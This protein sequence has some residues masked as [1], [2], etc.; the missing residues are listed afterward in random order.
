MG[1]SQVARAYF[2]KF[3]YHIKILN[4]VSPP[5]LKVVHGKTNQIRQT[6][7]ITINT[8]LTWQGINTA[9]SEP[10]V[11]LGIIRYLKYWKPVVQPTIMMFW[12]LSMGISNK[13][14]SYV[15]ITSGWDKRI[16]YL[17][18]SSATGYDRSEPNHHKTQHDDVIKWK[19]FPRNWPF[20]RGIHRSPVN[21]PHKGQWRGA[22]MFTL[23]CARINGWVNNR[24]AGDL[25]R[26]RA[27]YDVIVMG[28]GSAEQAARGRYSSS[29]TV[30]CNCTL[31]QN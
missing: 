12:K 13:L 6:S 25:R 7:I 4:Y 28:Y 10:Y 26:H 27:H 1:F 3:G 24:E 20:V 9:I 30:I 23:I 21:S 11:M 29:K 14:L 5:E 18:L 22:L 31:C 16:I 2:A 17:T 8:R 15:L 19:H